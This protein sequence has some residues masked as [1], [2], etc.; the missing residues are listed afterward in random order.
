MLP[1]TRSAHTDVA[2]CTR[3]REAINEDHGR[4]PSSDVTA[5]I[6]RR[7]CHSRA[8]VLSPAPHGAASFGQP[9]SWP[10][11]AVLW[12]R[13][14]LGWMFFTVGA[15]S[16][17]R[18]GPLF[19]RHTRWCPHSRLAR[20]WLRPSCERSF[21]GPFPY[22]TANTRV[23]R[24]RRSA[25]LSTGV[26]LYTLP[27]S[28]GR[29]GV[30]FSRVAKLTTAGLLSLLTKQAS[31]TPRPSLDLGDQ[32][33]HFLSTFAVHDGGRS[34]RTNGCTRL[35]H[36]RQHGPGY[37]PECVASRQCRHRHNAGYRTLAPG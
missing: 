8:G 15:P 29:A 12:P 10:L 35:S 5:P 9:L 4:V 31:S 7:R 19:V 17:K 32:R 23:T 25:F 3:V 11:D 33:A 22:P 14:D 34:G 20:A 18:P 24:P 6:T 1:L 27:R 26:D 36:R 2:I 21:V 16:L 37:R 13:R 28:A 30:P